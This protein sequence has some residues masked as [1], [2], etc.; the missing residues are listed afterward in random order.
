MPSTV[1][2][3]SERRVSDAW[4]VLE[5]DLTADMVCFGHELLAE[6]IEAE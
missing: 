2:D 5:D 1:V 3:L 6:S 4:N